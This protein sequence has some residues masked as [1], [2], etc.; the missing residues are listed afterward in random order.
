[1][2]SRHEESCCQGH[3][4]QHGDC[5]H[6]TL[7]GHHHPADR[8]GPRLLITLGL[9]LLIPAVQ[10]V[11]GIQARSM[12]LISD[13]AHNFSD[14]TAVLIAYV[15]NR[16][17]RRG[18]S[19]RNTFGYRR[20]EILAAVINVALLLAVSVFFIYEAVE[21]LYNPQ[22]VDG[23]IVAVVAGIGV[24][25]NGLSALLLHR[26]S[27]HNLNVRGAFLHMLG[28]L[29]TSVVVVINGI[30][31]IYKPW[32]WLDPALTVLIV[33]FI[34]RNCWVILKEAT[35]ILMNATPNGIDIQRVKGF[36]ERI[37]GIVSVHYL[38]AWNVCSSSIAFSCHVVV[39]DQNL[40]GIDPLAK[41][42]RGQL[43]RHFGIDHPILQ[44]E[45]T[46]CGDGGIFCALSCAG[47][48]TPP[49]SGAPPRRDWISFFRKPIRF[50]LRLA[51]GAVFIAASVDKIVHPAAFAKIIYNYQLLP[52]SLINIA[53]IVLPWLELTLG[54]LLICGVWL[55]GAVVLTNLL[56]A[57]FFASLVFNVFRGINVHCG[58][59][60]TAAAGDPTIAWYMV[61]DSVFLSAGIALLYETFFR[62]RVL[63]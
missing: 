25:G 37:P 22:V 49:E 31:L 28:D 7:G 32:Y 27:H 21:R 44:F 54:T 12:A 46:P 23:F 6:S 26:D 1:M 48:E 34:L 62:G 5:G 51:L 29:L 45:T 20:T 9:N 58:C 41:S 33:F 40:S 2:A 30:V 39:P 59:F 60:S 15:A 38:H 19:A 61:R 56:L 47:P 42:I 10:V 13:A 53:A 36:L 17:A 14:F 18:A 55:P 43:L 24:V 3:D 57:A 4:Q 11:G 35:C 8:S 16:I 52:D 63:E 50:W